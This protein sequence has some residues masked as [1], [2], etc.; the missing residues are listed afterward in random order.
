MFHKKTV[1][2]PAQEIWRCVGEECR[3]GE[4]DVW[5]MCREWVTTWK[6]AIVV[7]SQVGDG[8]VS[9]DYC[10]F[11]QTATLN[12]CIFIFLLLFSQK[13]NVTIVFSVKFS[14]RIIFYLSF[15]KMGYCCFHNEPFN[16]TFKPLTSKW[17][18]QGFSYLPSHHY[19]HIFWK[20]SY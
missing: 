17:V 16:S 2:R 6:T 11:H 1:S 20:F 19:N 8:L 18:W 4:A 7:A 14:F 15:G 5:T 13:T 12:M 10:Y 9:M 3:A